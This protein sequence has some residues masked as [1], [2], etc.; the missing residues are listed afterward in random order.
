[1]YEDE[2]NDGRFPDESPVEIRYPR[3]ELEEQGDRS[4]VALAAWGDCRTV[5]PRRMVRVRGG[6]GAGR[7]ARRSP[8]SARDRQP[9]PLLSLLLQGQLGDP[10]AHHF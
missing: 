3:S 7:A 8:R 9:K 6:Q 2:D 4:Q 5:R 10:A 1:M